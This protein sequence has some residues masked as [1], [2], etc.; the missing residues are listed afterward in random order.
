MPKE[1]SPSINLGEIQTTFVV[2]KRALAASEQVLKRAQDAR[3][4][5]RAGFSAAEAALR[6]ATR[7]LLG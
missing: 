7:A 3:D 6:D 2:S 4:K 5:A 1:R